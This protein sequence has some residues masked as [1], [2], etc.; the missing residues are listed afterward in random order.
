MLLEMQPSLPFL[1][2]EEKQLMK[3][4]S[5]SESS[6]IEGRH[7]MTTFFFILLERTML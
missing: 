5:N 7:Y 6:R 1:H 4:E 2:Q 3:I